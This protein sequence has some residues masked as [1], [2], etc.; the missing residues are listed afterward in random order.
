MK[1]TKWILFVACALGISALNTM[2][3]EIGGNEL[4]IELDFTYASKYIWH[5]Y[6]VYNDHGAFQPRV[7]L[8][9]RGIYAGIMG[10]WA[11]TSGFTDRDEVDFFAGY[12]CTFFEDEWYA[13]YNYITY[14]YYSHPATGD[15]GDIQELAN[16]LSFPKLFPLGPSFLVPRYDSFYIWN[17]F[18]GSRFID[19]GNVHEFGLTYDLPVPSLLPEQDNQ[20]VRLDWA[21]D[22]NDGTLTS[23]S[24]WSHTTIG[25]ST[26]FEWKGIFFVPALNYLWSLDSAFNAVNDENECYATF[27]V[28]Y[29]F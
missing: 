7:Q 23:N 16:G 27:K 24:D 21:V 14:T 6:D 15:E 18:Q 8:D 5:G 25:V 1:Q 11:D 28:G 13:I 29:R 12:E 3:V 17:G 10:S 20:T 9:Y 2:A 4:G 22:Y 19:N 26:R